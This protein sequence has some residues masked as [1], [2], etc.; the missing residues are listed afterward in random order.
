MLAPFFE[1]VSDRL[2]PLAAAS[3]VADT[4]TGETL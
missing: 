1:L 4:L 3:S 2:T